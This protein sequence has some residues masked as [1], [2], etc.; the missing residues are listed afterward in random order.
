[1]V[2]TGQKVETWERLGYESYGTWLRACAKARRAAFKKAAPP[3]AAKW[4]VPQFA[5]GNPVAL[6]LAPPPTPF[7]GL[8]DGCDSVRLG[9]YLPGRMRDDVILTP[10]GRREHKLTHVS[11]G[12]TTRCDEYSSPAGVD[13]AWQERHACLER[14]RTA[15]GAP[16]K[17]RLEQEA[18]R[19]AA[20]LD[21]IRAGIAVQGPARNPAAISDWGWNKSWDNHRGRGRCDDCE[22]CMQRAL[23][24]KKRKGVSHMAPCRFK[25]A[26][27][28]Y[29]DTE[30]DIIRDLQYRVD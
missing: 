11:P 15:R 4:H 14:M 2:S 16:A 28:G 18:A 6:S 23:A 1:M 26:F 21:A 10:R 25:V 29:T 9:G 3:P 12:G 24:R 5:P 22:Q 27:L 8:D 13:A 30:Q 19:R 17:V 7:G 20:G